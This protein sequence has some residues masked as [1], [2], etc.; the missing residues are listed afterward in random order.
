MSDIAEANTGTTPVREGYEIDLAALTRWMEAHGEDFAPE[1][2]MGAERRLAIR[3][4]LATPR[5]RRG[6]PRHH[7]TP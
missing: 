3:S 1:L 4:K 2:R 6:R 7:V 5:L